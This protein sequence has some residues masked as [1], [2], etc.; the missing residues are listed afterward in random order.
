M[1]GQSIRTKKG[2]K[3]A[4]KGHL[5]IL[6][7]E[8]RNLSYGSSSVFLALISDILKGHGEDV[9]HCIINDPEA[10]SLCLKALQAKALMQ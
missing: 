8:T 4:K 7:L 5:K 9:T 6:I 2:K 3:M 1:P 10:D